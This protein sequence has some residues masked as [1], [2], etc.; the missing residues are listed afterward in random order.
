MNEDPD[1]VRKQKLKPHMC[2]ERY[3]SV[4]GTFTVVLDLES[5]RYSLIHRQRGNAES[6][7]MRFSE[8]L[9]AESTEL[10]RRRRRRK[11]FQ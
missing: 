1:L 10:F 9:N 6:V 4:S 7:L 2:R 3:C 8:M 11:S 5:I